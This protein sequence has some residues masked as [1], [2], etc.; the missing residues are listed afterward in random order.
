M[1]IFLSVEIVCTGSE[2]AG[3]KSRSLNYDVKATIEVDKYL[4]VDNLIFMGIT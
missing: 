1:F 2:S 3:I 4:S